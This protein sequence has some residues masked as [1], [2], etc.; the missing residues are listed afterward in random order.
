M[1]SRAISF[2]AMLAAALLMS[3]SGHHGKLK[4]TLSLPVNEA[5][6]CQMKGE[7]PA[8]QCALFLF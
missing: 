3:T 6:N 4:R 2:N 8:R 1:T 5:R 7:T